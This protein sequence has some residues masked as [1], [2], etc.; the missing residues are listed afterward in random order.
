MY[1]YQPACP[2]HVIQGT[3]GWKSYIAKMRMC[4]NLVLIYERKSIGTVSH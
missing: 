4:W 3:E 1:L 2:Y